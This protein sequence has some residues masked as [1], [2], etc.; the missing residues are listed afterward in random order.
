LGNALNF[1]P[2]ESE[3]IANTPPLKIIFFDKAA[4]LTYLNSHK[5]AQ[6]IFVRV[7]DLILERSGLSG[8]YHLYTKDEDVLNGDYDLVV[9]MSPEYAPLEII[10]SKPFMKVETVLFFNKR[11]N[12]DQ[13]SHKWLSAVE[14]VSLPDGI[15]L[16]YVKY[17]PSRSESIKAVDKGRADYGFANIFSIAYYTIKDN[18]KNI[19]TVPQGQDVRYCS[20]GLL[21]EDPVLLSILNKVIDS[22]DDN[23][24]NTLIVSEAS[25][26][27][28]R[29]TPNMILNTYGKWLV[30]FSVLVVIVLIINTIS[31][32]KANQRIKLQNMRYEALS[33]ISNECLYEYQVRERHLI[34]SKQC[35]VLF[36]SGEKMVEAKLLLTDALQVSEGATTSFTIRLP[37][38]SG[39]FGTFKTTT[40]YLDGSNSIIGKLVDVSEEEAEKQE[41][42]VRSQVDGLSG[43]LNATAVKEAI[44]KV[45]EEREGERPH[46]FIL[47]DIDNFKEINDTYGHLFGDQVLGHL[48]ESLR[49][50]FANQ[51]IVGRFGGDE[52]CAYISNGATLEEVLFSCKMVAQKMGSS[53]GGIKASLS[54]GVTEVMR[55]EP[56]EQFFKRADASL[57]T[58]KLNGKDQV[59]VAP[60]QTPIL[61]KIN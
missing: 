15:D 48:G 10:L 28:R 37:L 58:A 39:E 42:L 13:L 18:L 31:I 46:F 38:V 3:Y 26:I 1:T 20:I 27:E 50:I 12:P 8:E 9:G 25:N 11:V 40:L 54:F 35:L 5:E 23:S 43:V 55:D 29:V 6:G 21:K 44:F 59:V 61:A 7:V 30:L 22:I 47:L 36:G 33:Q 57:Y 60:S 2:L 53:V 32:F 19:V 17:F 49:A 41:L 51:G 14:G 24:L 34:M 4:P 56:F 16:N 45:L 52:F